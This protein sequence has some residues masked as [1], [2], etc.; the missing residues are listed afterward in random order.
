MTRT[1]ETAIIVLEPFKNG[2]AEVPVMISPDLREAHD[3]ECNR[4]M[5]RAAVQERYPNLDF[6][7][8]LENWNYEPHTVE[9]A[10]LRAERVRKSL[11]ELTTKYQN[12]LLIAHRGFLAFLVPGP[13]FDVC[14]KCCLSWSCYDVVL[15][16]PH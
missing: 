13:R 11:K 15:D 1:I 9:A 2:G 5:A 6:M 7:R 10:T 14:G 3:A 4:G 12:T 16:C 8:C